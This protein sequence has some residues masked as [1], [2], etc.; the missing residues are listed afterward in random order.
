MKKIILCLVL[1]SPVLCFAQ[2][3]TDAMVVS[4]GVADAGLAGATAVADAGITV[5]SVGTDGGV[6][7]VVP[8]LGN[9]LLSAKEF[10]AA[11][12][13]G[14][15]WLA[16][17]FMLFF[18]VGAIRMGGKK[19]HAFIPDDTKNPVL[20]PIEAFLRFIFDTKI[21]GWV[22]NWLS[23]IGGC[24]GAATAAGMPVDA[25]AWK[26]ALLAS[27][28][29]TAVYELKD[30]IMEWWTARQAAKAAVVPAIAVVVPKDET[31]KP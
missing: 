1:V 24:L 18:L 13:T 23:A 16:A 15:G 22:L 30:D 14:N 17:M 25:A 26:V 5:V 19:L 6:V 2:D 4:A 10:Y 27:T 21:G 20:K 29:G 28:G 31:T 7:T 9:P 8:A 3:A 11:V 12:K